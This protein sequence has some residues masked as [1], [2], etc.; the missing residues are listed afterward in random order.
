MLTRGHQATSA[1]YLMLE[2][3]GMEI[4]LLIIRVSA[5]ANTVNPCFGCLHGNTRRKFSRT[6][7]LW[8]N[9][10]YS[11]SKYN[12]HHWCMLVQSSGRKTQNRNHFPKSIK[13]N[14]NYSINSS[15]KCAKRWLHLLF[16]TTP[17]S[18]YKPHYWK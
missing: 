17:Y 2:H 13:W 6:K 1:V 12:F 3:E 11:R 18:H 4:S 7:S 16:F 15:M 9:F 14:G 8:K 5:T 10:Y